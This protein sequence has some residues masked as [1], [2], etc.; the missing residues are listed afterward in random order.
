[1]VV[2]PSD[3]DTASAGSFFTNPILTAD[4]LA[5]LRAR[6]TDIAAPLPTFPDASGHTKVSAAW[7]IERAGFT[8]GFAKGRAGISSKHALALVNRGDATTGEIVDLAR[9]IRDGVRAR[10]GVTLEN[11]PVFVGVRL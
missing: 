4:E 9:A 6:V 3:R 8:K 1:M 10:F 7:L 2:D 5:A 11:E